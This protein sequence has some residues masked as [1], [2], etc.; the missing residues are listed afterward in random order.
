MFANSTI[1]EMPEASI[2]LTT[3]TSLTGKG[4]SE[5]IKSWNWK[6]SV[7]DL[8]ELR[9]EEDVL[10][11]YLSPSWVK[12]FLDIAT[13]VASKSKDR[14]NVKQRLITAVKKMKP[15]KERIRHA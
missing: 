1:F 15:P 14:T 5:F 3:T 13:V 7:R 10:S 12:Y 8:M 4:A 11:V 2:Q 9:Q 6:C